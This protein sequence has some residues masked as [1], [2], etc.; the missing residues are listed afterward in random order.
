MPRPVYPTH[1]RVPASPLCTLVQGLTANID[2]SE[3]R[4]VSVMFINCQ[5]GSALPDHPTV[6]P[7]LT[8]IVGPD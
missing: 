6:T 2:L 5:V 4:S 8:I 7:T 1:R 3:M